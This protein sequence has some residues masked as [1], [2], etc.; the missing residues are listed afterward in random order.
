MR[1]RDGGM[2]RRR[3]MG[4]TFVETLL[5][6]IMIGIL[7]G[8]AAR[9]LL[10]GLDIYAFIVNRNNAFH[11]A[12]VAMERMVDE[13]LLIDSGDI[14]YLGSTRFGF[15]DVDGISTDFRS[16]TMSRDGVSVPCIYRGDDFLAGNVV[17]L[18]FDYLKDDG[19]TTIFSPWVR[20]IN[21]DFTVTAL[22]GAGDVHL[23]T[24]VYP[25]NFMYSGFQ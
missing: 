5:V 3:A 11:N 15:R 24:D 9:V 23:R 10:S 13:T 19:S 21:I 25:R 1:G 16:R 20:R 17:S 8:I 22:A 14:T 12:R 7:G 6:I 4:F 2:K 18:D